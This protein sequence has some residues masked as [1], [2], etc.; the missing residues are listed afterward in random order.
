MDWAF[1]KPRERGGRRYVCMC[2]YMHI[3]Q[4]RLVCLLVLFSSFLFVEVENGD[5]LCKK[6]HTMSFIHTCSSL[7]CKVYSNFII[8]CIYICIIIL[9]MH[10]YTKTKVYSVLSCFFSAT[11]DFFNIALYLCMRK[12]QQITCMPK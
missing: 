12:R 4:T 9:K 1:V 6:K 11:L 3:F 2:T 7:T 5:T 10:T 8:V